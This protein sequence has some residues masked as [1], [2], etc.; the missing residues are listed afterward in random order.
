MTNT[1]PG[2][3]PGD[4][5]P[6]VDSS[7][8]VDTDSAVEAEDPASSAEEALA[9]AERWFVRHGVPHFAENP[10][11]V[12]GLPAFLRPFAAFIRLLRLG[13]M[14][15]FW[16]VRR[17][18]AEIREVGHL[19]VR[20]LPLLALFGMVIFFTRDFWQ[21]A[22]ALASGWLWVTAAFFVL[23][24]Q[25]FLVARLPEEF[26]TLPKACTPD[27]IRAS[28]AA[29]PLAE[30][31]EAEGELATDPALGL[32]QR[33][34][35]FLYLLLTQTIQISLLSWMVFFFYVVFGAIAIRPPVLKDWFGHIPP[36][37]HLLGM[38]VPGVSSE[39]LHVAVLL[40]GL[41]ALY[42]AITALTDTVYRREFFDRTL[43]E[44]DKAI[45]MRCAYLTVRGG[46]RS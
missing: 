41:S 5:G 3:L 13:A 42:F 32:G 4:T 1:D 16:S 14:L 44:L 30:L 34:N 27:R 38:R 6:P 12:S 18:F 11:Y 20:A 31:A 39:L 25:A 40:A 46:G 36:D 45:H 19:A 23:L 21:I 43:A 33:R 35:M 22:A 7:P 37:A 9:A 24:I 15:G 29:T 26:G 10:Y 2:D 17:V 28:C 8:S